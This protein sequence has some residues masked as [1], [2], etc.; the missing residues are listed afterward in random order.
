MFNI[1]YNQICS[2]IKKP[3]ENKRVTCTDLLEV[4]TLQTS[5]ILLMA[6]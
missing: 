5:T 4:K 3:A 2:T 6:F 1:Y